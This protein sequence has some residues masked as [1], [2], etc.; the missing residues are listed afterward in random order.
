[1][2]FDT[3]KAEIFESERELAISAFLAQDH[4]AAR[5]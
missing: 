2:A 1:M 3:S 5:V 4:R